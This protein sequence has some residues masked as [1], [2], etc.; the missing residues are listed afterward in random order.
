MKGFAKNGIDYSE[1]EV[2]RRKPATCKVCGQMINVGDMAI[3]L[4]SDGLCGIPYTVGIFHSK[5]YELFE[6][7][8]LN[9]RIN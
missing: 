8:K 7:E 6:F 2:K 3:V 1:K 5:C 4:Q 9:L